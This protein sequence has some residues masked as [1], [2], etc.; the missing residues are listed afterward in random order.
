M[1]ERDN[2]SNPP[3]PLNSSRRDFLK[4]AGGAAMMA[5][6]MLGAPGPTSSRALNSAARCL[7]EKLIRIPIAAVSFVDAG[8]EKVLA[9]LPQRAGV[10]VLMLAVFTSGRAIAGRQIP[11]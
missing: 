5:G 11:G 7:R 1:N 8:V 6:T 4:R 10:N 2:P 3:M 9:S